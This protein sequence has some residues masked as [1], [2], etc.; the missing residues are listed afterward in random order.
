MCLRKMNYTDICVTEGQKGGPGT[1]LSI[2]G[3][4]NT[5][6][7]ESDALCSY[8]TLKG[9]HDYAGQERCGKCSTFKLE[10]NKINH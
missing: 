2:L 10:K 7:T 8:S 9:W 6:K 1:G 3:R 4:L 5:D